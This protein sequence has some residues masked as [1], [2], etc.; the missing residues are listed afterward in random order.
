MQLLPITDGE[1]KT[2]ESTLALFTEIGSS[3]VLA[4]QDSAPREGGVFLRLQVGCF[5]STSLEHG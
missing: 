2:W 1:T 3:N 5:A 4:G